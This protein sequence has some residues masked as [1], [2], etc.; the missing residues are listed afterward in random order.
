MYYSAPP[1]HPPKILVSFAPRPTFFRTTTHFETSAPTSKWHWTLQEFKGTSY[2]CL[3]FHR[4]S[5]FSLFA[6][7]RA[8]F[9]LNVI[10]VKCTEYPPNNLEAHIYMS[11]LLPGPGFFFV[12]LCDKPLYLIA[13]F[14]FYFSIR[15]NVNFQSLKLF[16]STLSFKIL[17]PF[18]VV[19]SDNCR[20]TGVLKVLSVC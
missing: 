1:P 8:V 12:S 17:S 10:S 5:N 3:Q 13:A 11:C 9:E 15:H 7:R 6:A 18:E 14:F 20:S 2:M 16:F 4:G 19:T